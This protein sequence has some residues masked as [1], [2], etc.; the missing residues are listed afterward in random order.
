[1]QG[2]VPVFSLRIYTI[3]WYR[4]LC[5]ENIKMNHAQNENGPPGLVQLNSAAGLNGF[6]AFSTVYWAYF[7]LVANVSLMTPFLKSDPACNPTHS[8]SLLNFPS[9]AVTQKFP[10]AAVESF[11]PP[12]PPPLSPS[13]LNPS[14]QLFPSSSPSL[15]S[16]FLMP[17]RSNSCPA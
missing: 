4:G 9:T 15:V 1:M 14:I 7:L 13:L 16:G 5:P 6:E 11:P 12:T 3:V 17:R 2:V 10:P 8:N